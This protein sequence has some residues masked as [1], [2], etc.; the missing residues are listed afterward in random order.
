MWWFCLRDT[1]IFISKYE[2]ASRAD[3]CTPDR[4][5][6]KITAQ[7]RK[8]AYLLMLS[9]SLERTC[10]RLKVIEECL[11]ACSVCITKMGDMPIYEHVHVLTSILAEEHRRQSLTGG[12]SWQVLV[13]VSSRQNL[14]ASWC[15]FHLLI[16]LRASLLLLFLAYL[17]LSGGEYIFNPCSIAVHL[18]TDNFRRIFHSLTEEGK[19]AQLNHILT[20]T[21]SWFISY[22]KFFTFFFFTV[23][24][25]HEEGTS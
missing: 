1:Y 13:W 7:E 25:G 21:I 20:L 3:K 24:S 6:F 18:E 17:F 15:S 5:R 8:R 4:V 9:W 23:Y 14:I 11:W 22:R 12:V 16:L 19:F 10:Y 2:Y